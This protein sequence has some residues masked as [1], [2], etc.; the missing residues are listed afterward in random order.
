[1]MYH[2]GVE[3]AVQKRSDVKHGVVCNVIIM[4]LGVFDS[5]ATYVQNRVRTS[6]VSAI[7]V[8]AGSAGWGT[9]LKVLR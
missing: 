8:Y 5:K 9:C 4:S 3:T 1:M 6:G 2:E 7:C